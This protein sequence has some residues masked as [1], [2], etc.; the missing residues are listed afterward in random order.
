MNTVVS[1]PTDEQAAVSVTTVLVHK[2]I[3]ALVKHAVTV[4]CT[5]SDDL[6]VIIVSVAP[7]DV[8]RVVG[9]EGR[10]LR[11]IRTILQATSAKL[12]RRFELEVRPCDAAT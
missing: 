10:T 8:T 5:A 1:N 4:H 11:S 6:I 3:S 7:E 2:V 12:H 9:F